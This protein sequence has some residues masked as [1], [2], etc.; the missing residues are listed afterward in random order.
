MNYRRCL[1]ISDN[2]TQYANRGRKYPRY[3]LLSFTL[4][5]WLRSNYWHLLM[6][7]VR[8]PFHHLSS[9]LYV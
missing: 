4:T 5:L 7:R 1:E 2:F 6:R 9:R 3:E 8:F